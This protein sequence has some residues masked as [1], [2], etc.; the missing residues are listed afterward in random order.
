M[1]CCRRSCLP[2]RFIT[3]VWSSCVSALQQCGQIPAFSRSCA[4]LRLAAQAKYT[5]ILCNRFLLETGLRH[6]WP[7]MSMTKAYDQKLRSSLLQ[8]NSSTPTLT[9]E[10]DTVLQN[11]VKT[12]G[13]PNVAAQ[14]VARELQQLVHVLSKDPALCTL[15]ISVQ[16]SL[17]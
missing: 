13:W 8:P 3:C 11:L 14:T 12:G 2:R 5:S 17:A 7:N 6:C 16:S 15:V 1:T 9:T 10:A 4:E